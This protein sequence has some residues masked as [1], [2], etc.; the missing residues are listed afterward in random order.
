MAAQI[1]HQGITAIPNRR[2]ITVQAGKA[3]AAA[4]RGLS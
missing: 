2:G 3:A 4:E 1:T